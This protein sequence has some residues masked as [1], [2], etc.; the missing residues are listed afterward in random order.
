MAFC[1]VCSSCVCAKATRKAVCIV[2]IVPRSVMSVVFSTHDA[3]R[4]CPH[5]SL[6]LLPLQHYTGPPQNASLQALHP[7]PITWLLPPPSPPPRPPVLLRLPPP[8]FL[9]QPAQQEQQTARIIRHWSSPR[10]C[11]W[12]PS[13]A[14][15]WPS[16]FSQVFSY[17]LLCVH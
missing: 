7:R 16:P 11:S 2:V 13:W 1:E 3:L 5:S 9:L 4:P 10:P 15:A 8:L 17:L 12:T 14:P 6:T